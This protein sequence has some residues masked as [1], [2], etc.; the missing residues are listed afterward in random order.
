MKIQEV[1]ARGMIGLFVRPMAGDD[2][3]DFKAGFKKAKVLG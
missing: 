3:V 1:I 2:P